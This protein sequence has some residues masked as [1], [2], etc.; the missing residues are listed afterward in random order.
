MDRPALAPAL[1]ALIT[2]ALLTVSFGTAPAATVVWSSAQ[3]KKPAAK[4]DSTKAKPAAPANVV[5][6]STNVKPKTAGPVPAVVAD[7][8]ATNA[9]TAGVKPV[10]PAAP[11]SPAPTVPV[12]AKP[13]ATTP[14][15][16]PATVTPPVRTP[17]AVVQTKAPG[18]VPSETSA[19]A[20]R[21]ARTPSV[22]TA[23]APAPLPV[24]ARPAAPVVRTNP[25]PAPATS[26]PA[27]SPAAA[28]AAPRANATSGGATL[29]TS[30]I[31]YLAGASAYVDAG[32]MDGLTAGDTVEVLR[33]GQTIA[34]LRVTFV[35]SK[36]AS[37]DTLWTR[38]AI[39]LGDVA[40][41][42]SD[43]RRQA[44]TEDS[45]RTASAR[46][47]SIRVAAVLTPPKGRA[48]RRSSRLRGRLGG[49]WL[50]V[51]STGSR[52]QQPALDLRADARDGMGGHMDASIDVRARR[53]VRTGD[54][55]TVVDQFSRVYRAS[56]TFRDKNDRR[57]FTLGRQSSPT[58]ASI[59]LFDGALLEVGDQRHT[60]GAFA[61]TQPEPL[62]F[63]WSGDLVEGGA[64]AEWHQKPLA[65]Q[66]WSVSVGGVTSR[67]GAAV[68]RDFAFAQGWWFAKGAS[69]SVAQELDLNTGWK[70]D[71]GEPMLAWT[72]TF[73]TMRVPI[74]PQLAL[75]SGYDN[76]RSV[77]L[78][79]DRETPETDFDDRYRQG[80]W[81]GTTLELKQHIRS[82]AEYRTGSGGDHSDTWSVSGEV[83]RLTRWQCSVRTRISA[84]TSPGTESALSSFGAGFDP[85]GQSHFEFN[86]GTRRTR[87]R[88]TGFEE[89][90]RWQGID[91]DLAVGGRWYVN[92]GWEQQKGQTGTTRQLQAGVSVRL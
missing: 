21:P 13:I 37:C 90:E 66:R 39:A 89:T 71:M 41:Y 14:A 55:G 42:R 5:W 6:S 7:S 36:R 91:L 25:E 56:T 2:A 20:T 48:A 8:S 77:R 64:F 35:S 38:A 1:T 72:S 23:V 87:D 26:K 88:A 28:S 67:R 44:A 15:P 59:S 62:R 18:A 57:R 54:A 58:L 81:G 51:E 34:R 74:T 10:P 68:N 78:W 31:S 47:D 69:A 49:R 43:F 11:A 53:T 33:D 73:A 60:Y 29:R 30:R 82:S 16:V 32:Q 79:R 50:S 52:Y 9:S 61:G 83:Y 76:R 70:R 24:A 45:L 40:R 27:S 22:P 65:A 12:A 80:A 17:A 86:A 63:G 92:G 4:P 75:Q 84:F 3:F 46:G 85:L 19:A